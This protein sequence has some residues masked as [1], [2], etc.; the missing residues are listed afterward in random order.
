[1]RDSLVRLILS[2][3][4]RRHSME[5]MKA[6]MRTCEERTTPAEPSNAARRCRCSEPDDTKAGLPYFEVRKGRRCCA[7]VTQNPEKGLFVCLPAVLRPSW[8]QPEPGGHS[9][10]L[11]EN[12]HPEGRRRADEPK[13]RSAEGSCR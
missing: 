1:M 5:Q 8:G 2:A 13:S 7:E 4:E 10:R 11:R 12:S 6:P 3:D 9:P